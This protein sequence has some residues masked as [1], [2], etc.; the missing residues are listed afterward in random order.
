[1]MQ[2]YF[3]VCKLA[4]KE[5]VVVAQFFYFTAH[6]VQFVHLTEFLVVQGDSTCKTSQVHFAIHQVSSILSFSTGLRMS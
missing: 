5:F 1:M 6:F 4:Q 3:N 2:H